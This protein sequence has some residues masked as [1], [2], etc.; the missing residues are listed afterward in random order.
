MRDYRWGEPAAV[1]GN[2]TWQGNFV[3]A[4]QLAHTICIS[5]MLQKREHE[6]K[7]GKRGKKKVRSKN[8]KLIESETQRNNRGR[9][10]DSRSL[11]PARPHSRRPA[12]ASAA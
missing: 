2:M 9:K 8:N 11:S 10:T 7:G 3:I 4:T 6:Q 1:A 12:F 5:V